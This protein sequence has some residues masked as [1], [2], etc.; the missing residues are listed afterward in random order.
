MAETRYAQ[1]VGDILHLVQD[2]GSTVLAY[3]TATDLWNVGGVVPDPTPDPEPGGPRFQWPFPLSTVS[4]EYG[5]RSGRVHQGIDL[6]P[7][8]DV[9]IPAA[10]T[11]K[12]HISG[13]HNNFGNWVVIQH[14]GVGNSGYLYTVYAHM[15]APATWRTGQ[16]INRGQIVGR[17][18]NTGASFGAHLHFETHVGSLGWTN[19]GPHINPRV[20]MDRYAN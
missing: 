6:A 12:I 5:P 4:S 18:G 14:P 3:P 17:V 10:G 16:A 15:I 20:F 8:N 1:K 11:G 2:D 13:W 7:G 19:P 9:P